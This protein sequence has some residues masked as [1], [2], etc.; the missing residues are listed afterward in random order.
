[1]SHAQQASFAAPCARVGFPGAS[2]A[3][4]TGGVEAGGFFA[5]DREASLGGTQGQTA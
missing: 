2:H 5:G 1:M 3:N 4:V